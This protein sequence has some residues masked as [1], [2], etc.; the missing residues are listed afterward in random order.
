MRCTGPG[1]ANA[2]CAIRTLQECPLT[3]AHQALGNVPRNALRESWLERRCRKFSKR[4]GQ[5]RQSERGPMR[6]PPCGRAPIACRDEWRVE[7]CGEP[8]KSRLIIC[9]LKLDAIREP[10]FRTTNNF[11][12]RRRVPAQA[13][14]LTPFSKIVLMKPLSVRLRRPWNH[15]GRPVSVAMRQSPTPT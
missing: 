2:T 7:T 4:T 3:A 15:V 6:R 5:Q 13:G 1:A 9:G 12:R 14:V 11:L 8:D 10:I